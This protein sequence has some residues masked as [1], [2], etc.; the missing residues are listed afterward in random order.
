MWDLAISC[1]GARGAARG[2]S[3]SLF[4]RELAH[5]PPGV[6]REKLH[7]T[8]L[9]EFRSTPQVIQGIN[10]KTIPDNDDQLYALMQ[11]HGAPTRL[12]DW[13]TSPY[14]ASFFAFTSLPNTRVGH[15]RCAVH[16]LNKRASSWRGERARVR[17]VT[18]KPLVQGRMLAQE[19]LFT[20]NLSSQF[21]C[22]EDYCKAYYADSDTKE[23]AL[24]CITLPRDNVSAALK[25]LNYAMR[26]NSKNMF[27][28]LD[29]AARY[30]FYKTMMD[31]GHLDADH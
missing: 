27:P 1:S 28:D 16:V 20:L 8:I 9:K 26:I 10:R 23:W 4:D 19:A 29:G 5:V 3:K 31:A 17:L 22:L 21:D 14:I 13:T 6:E 25:E 15:E 11:H 18:A 2:S 30:A 24:R 7:E 12:L